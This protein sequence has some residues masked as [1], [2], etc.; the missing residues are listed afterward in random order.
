MSTTED[1]F[2][3]T[4]V[5]GAPEAAAVIFAG[6]A[7][8][9]VIKAKQTQS[10]RWVHILTGTAVAE[11]LGYIFRAVCINHI[12]LGMFVAMNLFLL[13]PPN[14]FALYE[15]KTVGQVVRH[16]NVQAKHFWLR[17]KFI[18]W[19]FFSSDVFSFLLQSTGASMMSSKDSAQSGKWIALVGLAVQLVFLACFVVTAIYVHRDPSY[20]VAR[21]RKDKTPEGAKKRLMYTVFA[22][23]ALIYIRSV[24]RLIEFADGYGGKIYSSEWPFYVFDFAMIL[25]GFAL[26]IVFFV[27]DHFSKAAINDAIEMC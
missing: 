15:Y 20:K 14:A 7:I 4:P 19:F 6:I 3:Y 2:T 16:S 17:P 5:H 27:G 22:T 24:Y 18:T 23:I 26:N 21:G 1:Y 12:S 10:P 8:L 9:V 25:A 11:S 13:L